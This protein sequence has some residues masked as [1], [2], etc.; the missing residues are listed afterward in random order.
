MKKIE[1]TA[2]IANAMATRRTVMT[3]KTLKVGQVP[4]ELGPEIWV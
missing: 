3:K 4:P 1:M 2:Q